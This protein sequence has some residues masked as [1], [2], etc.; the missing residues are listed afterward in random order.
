VVLQV[1]ALRT[2][3]VAS[4]VLSIAALIAIFWFKAGMIQTLLAC[5]AAGIILYFAGVIG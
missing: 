3:N 4:L 2:L 5:S 1:P